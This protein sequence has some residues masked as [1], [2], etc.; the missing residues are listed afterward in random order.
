MT[1]PCRA[2]GFLTGWPAPTCIGEPLSP[3][4]SEYDSRMTDEDIAECRVEFVPGPGRR[5]A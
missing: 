2:A 1:F 4:C 3:H 5:H